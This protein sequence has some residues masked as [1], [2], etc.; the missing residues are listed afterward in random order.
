MRV[1]VSSNAKTRTFLDICTQV[2]RL[3]PDPWHKQVRHGLLRSIVACEDTDE[4]CSVGGRWRAEDGSGQ[5]MCIGYTRNESVQFTC[6]ILFA[7]SKQ[8]RIDIPASAG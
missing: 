1:N 8:R 4:L 6:R 7:A 5:E 2:H 3:S